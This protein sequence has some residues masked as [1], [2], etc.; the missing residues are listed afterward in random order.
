MCY[1]SFLS[2][3]WGLREKYKTEN[4]YLTIHTTGNSTKLGLLESFT[5]DSVEDLRLKIN[6]NITMQFA[7]P[8]FR[9]GWDSR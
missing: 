9:R 4:I 1:L 7:G 3:F 8:G 2:L 5:F 6:K